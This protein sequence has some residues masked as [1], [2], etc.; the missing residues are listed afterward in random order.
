MS[1]TYTTQDVEDARLAQTYLHAARTN[2]G[3]PQQWLENDCFDGQ[4]LP[5]LRS[6]F[7]RGQQIL[8]TAQLITTDDRYDQTNG[9]A[10]NMAA[11]KLIER[12]AESP[13]VE[14]TAGYAGTN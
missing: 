10:Y 8:Q 6:Q 13:I 5:D 11:N 9:V 7:Q 12:G 4:L 2:G 3:T 14:F 1:T